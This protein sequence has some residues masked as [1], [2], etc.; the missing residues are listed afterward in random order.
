MHRSIL[1]F[2]SVGFSVN[3]LMPP[4][5]EKKERA[6]VCLHV[7]QFDTDAMWSSY[8]HIFYGVFPL[9]FGWLF[10]FLFIFG[11]FHV[12]NILPRLFLCSL[13]SQSAPRVTH[14]HTI[15]PENT[16]WKVGNLLESP[17]F[18]QVNACRGADFTS[19][20]VHALV[21]EKNRKKM[22][23]K[24]RKCLFHVK[25]PRQAWWWQEKSGESN[26]MCFQFYGL[27]WRN[28]SE[29]I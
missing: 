19:E 25:F 26:E 22:N 29:S 20:F 2:L 8:N 1:Y 16:C 13:F 14:F 21:T 17:L 18:F 24:K 12:R 5:K 4:E 10:I 6:S 23:F 9:V 15:F 11:E 27:H 3:I 7:F 28:S